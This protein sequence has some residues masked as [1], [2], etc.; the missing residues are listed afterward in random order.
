[1]MRWSMLMLLYY[2]VK[3]LIEYLAFALVLACMCVCMCVFVYGEY[4]QQVNNLHECLL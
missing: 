1:M 2:H 4:Y 3:S